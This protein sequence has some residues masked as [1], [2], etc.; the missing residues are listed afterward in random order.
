[1]QPIARG[2]VNEARCT[3]HVK[4]S[5]CL[6]KGQLQRCSNSRQSV[7]LVAAM[8]KY[9]PSKV[10]YADRLRHQQAKQATRHDVQN[11]AK[12]VENAIANG[13]LDALIARCRD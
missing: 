9:E 6:F 4:L 3:Y 1:M 7:Q 12:D 2:N 8:N 10:K 13:K 11:F 5:M